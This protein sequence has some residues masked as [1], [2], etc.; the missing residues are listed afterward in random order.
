MPAPTPVPTPAPTPATVPAPRHAVSDRS[1]HRTARAWAVGVLLAATL[2]LAAYMTLVMLAVALVVSLFGGLLDLGPTRLD[3]AGL[4]A[5][6]APGLLVGWCV[7]LAA[8]A[9]LVGRTSLGPRSTGL[10]AGLLGT[11]AGAGVLAL[12][13]VL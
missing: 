9:A 5:D 1:A 7:G 4:A 10:L 2:A 12:A 8:V 6:A 13:G 3:P 11:A